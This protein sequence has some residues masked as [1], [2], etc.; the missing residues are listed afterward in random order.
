MDPSVHSLPLLF[1]LGVQSRVNDQADAFVDNTRQFLFSCNSE[2][3]RHV[4]EHFCNLCGRYKQE[5]VRRRHAKQGILPLQSAIRKLQPGPEY[6]TP[7]H[8]DLFQLCL[9]AK[10]YNAGLPFVEEDIF[11]VD[12]VKT[13][14]TPTRFQLY[15]YYGAM[16]CIGRKQH[17]RALELLLQSVTAPTNV[18]SAIAMAAYRKYVCV[19]LIHLGSVPALPKFTSSKVRQA[20]EYECRAYN[21]L[22][23]AFG[24]HNIN[25]LRKHAEQHHNDWSKHHDVGLVQQVCHSLTMRNVQRLT[26]TYLTLSLGAIADMVGLRGAQ[27]AEALVLRMVEA[28]QVYAAIDSQRGM[29]KFLD[30]PEAYDTPDTAAAIDARMAECAAVAAR[31]SAMEE[32]VSLERPYLTKVAGRE[33]RG[34]IE[35]L[36]DIAAAGPM[37]Y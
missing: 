25:R 26:H 1:I 22:A 7:I 16:L 18:V 2:H 33:R 3:I 13:A 36:D 14:M 15:C 28:G 37:V 31:V 24:S 35:P 21:E 11:D 19:S 5:L 34:G 4:P 12:P 10:C 30:D 27:E 32:A 29:V 20:T 23:S 6:L 8:A 17:G 9:L